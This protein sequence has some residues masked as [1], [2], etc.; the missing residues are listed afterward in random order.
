MLPLELSRIEELRVASD[1]RS[2]RSGVRD[3][4]LGLVT[5]KRRDCDLSGATG[6]LQRIESSEVVRFEPSQPQR[7]HCLLICC[8][9]G[10]PR[11]DHLF[12]C[13]DL[14]LATILELFK[15]QAADLETTTSLTLSTKR[16]ISMLSQVP[17]DRCVGVDLPCTKGCEYWGEVGAAG[18]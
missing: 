10:G 3:A 7:S 2:C 6:V 12:N 1:Q 13:L 14:G 11:P 16:H 9:G 18:W 17:C 5:G 8:V 15:L 4:G